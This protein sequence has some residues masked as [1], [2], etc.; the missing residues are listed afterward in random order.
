MKNISIY[1]FLTYFLFPFVAIIGFTCL[2]MLIIALSNP[3]ALL[4][5]FVMACIVIYTVSSFIFLQKGIKNA[6]PCKQSLKDWIKVNAYVAML[7]AGLML[8]ESIGLFA[9]PNLLRTG[10][11]EAM[12]LQQQSL[13]PQITF[14][15][16]LKAMKIILICMSI[17]S[18]VLIIHILLTFKLLKTFKYVFDKA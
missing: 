16:M 7:L 5:L 2:F 15:I 10:L 11:E 3:A 18:T 6:K 14:G 12:R 9:N 8:I 17:F 1:T 13:P 4:P